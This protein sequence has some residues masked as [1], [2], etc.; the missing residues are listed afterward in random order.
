M[1]PLWQEDRL[2]PSVSVIVA[3]HD[4]DHVIERRIEYEYRPKVRIR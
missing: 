3:A 4:E 1:R 2:A